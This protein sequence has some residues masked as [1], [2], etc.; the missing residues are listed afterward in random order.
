MNLLL[1]CQAVGLNPVCLIYFIL[2]I[3]V[4]SKTLVGGG[5]SK[6]KPVNAW[7]LQ[8]KDFTK[9]FTKSAGGSPLEV[10]TLIKI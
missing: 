7:A 8:S 9:K 4:L 2:F 5:V 3:L 1:L 6:F 10:C